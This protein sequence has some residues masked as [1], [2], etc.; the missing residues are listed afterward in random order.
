MIKSSKKSILSLLIMV[1]VLTSFFSLAEAFSLDFNPAAFFQKTI[2]L[3]LNKVSD[4]IYYLVIQKKNAFGLPSDTDV[5]IELVASSSPVG[6][7]VSGPIPLNPVAIDIKAKTEDILP[8][9]SSPKINFDV[10]SS[11]NL[12]EDFSDNNSQILQYTNIERGNLSLQPLLANNVLDLVAELR[13]DDL[14]T[15]Q[16][17]EHESPDGK[18]VS[19][20]VEQLGYE[21]L[22]IGEN[23]ALGNYTDNQEIVLSWMESPGHKANILN[24]KYTDLGVAVKE[25]KYKGEITTIAVQ[26]FALPLTNC[27]RPNQGLKTLIDSSTISIKQMETEAL[28]MRNNLNIMNN[29]LL[30]DGAYYNQ[31]IQEYNLFAERVNNAIEAL[32]QIVSDY[33]LEVSEYNLCISL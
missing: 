23:L 28:L 17:F 25:G 6:E 26:V 20:I 16:Y 21:Y 8:D 11:S 12:I 33:N 19:D 4:T 31:K 10:I 9:N 32:K 7:I 22:S 5:L 14:F 15:N 1:I 18:S 2:S 3:I 27:S 29:D 24:E 13:A 30:I